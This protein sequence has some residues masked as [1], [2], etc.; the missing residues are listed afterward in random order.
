MPRT[1]A[2]LLT[3]LAGL[4]LWLVAAG[5][6][7]ALD[8]NYADIGLQCGEVAGKILGGAKAGSIPV[9]GPRK[10]AYSLNLKTASVLN[11]EFPE[12]ILKGAQQVIR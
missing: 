5:A 11:V 10:V 2:A 4:V 6:L 3:Y 7:Y 1:M 12:D 9:T 8:R